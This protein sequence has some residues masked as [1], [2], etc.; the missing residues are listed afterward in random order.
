MPDPNMRILVVDDFHTMRRV[1]MAV[2]NQLGFKNIE[3]AGDGEQAY[4][5]LKTGGFDFVVTD[6][7][8]PKMTGVE[9]LR[10]I[11][12][13]DAIKDLPVL[14]VTAETEKSIVVEAIQAGVNNYIVKPFTA[15]IFQ[16]KMNKIFE[17]IG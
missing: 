5:I 15:Q 8:M 12:A 16:E 11:R 10:S 2:L 6:W 13:N 14:M 4:K 9:L 1:I 17:K 3:E 7:N